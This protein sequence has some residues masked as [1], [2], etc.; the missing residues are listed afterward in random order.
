MYFEQRR[1]KLICIITLFAR[2]SSRIRKHPMENNA[3]KS[4]YRPL[5]E[6]KKNKINN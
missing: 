2:E 4:T 5:A 3:I 1:K 6:I